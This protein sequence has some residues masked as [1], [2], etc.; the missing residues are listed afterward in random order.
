MNGQY[1]GCQPGGKMCAW[2]PFS[3]SVAM[4]LPGGKD[5]QPT[6]LTTIPT[7]FSVTNWN[8]ANVKAMNA[9]A[10]AATKEASRIWGDLVCR[11]ANTSAA[12]TTI[13]MKRNMADMTASP[14][15]F[16]E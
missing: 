6:F 16:I 13:P 8:E 15:G 2:G 10:D 12:A 4:I 9:T 5:F 1:Q 7:S 11:A 3:P 14:V